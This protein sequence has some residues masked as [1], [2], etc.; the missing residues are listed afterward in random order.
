MFLSAESKEGFGG[1]L[2]VYNQLVR[3]KRNCLNSAWLGKWQSV[4][5]SSF[6]FPVISGQIVSEYWIEL[7]AIYK[8]TYIYISFCMEALPPTHTGIASIHRPMKGYHFQWRKSCISGNGRDMSE[9]L[10]YPIISNFIVLEWI[11]ELEGNK[12]AVVVV[13]LGLKSQTKYHWDWFAVFNIKD[14]QCLI[15]IGPFF[16]FFIQDLD[17]GYINW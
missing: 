17:L 9:S 8:D 15:L 4:L 1:P 3:S 16:L 11:L 10:L 2:D 14:F 6:W 12:K 13:V 5:K 7:M